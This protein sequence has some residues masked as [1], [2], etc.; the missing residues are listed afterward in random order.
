[1]AGGRGRA[2]AVRLGLGV[3]PAWAAASLGAVAAAGAW[4]EALLVAAPEELLFRGAV[5]GELRARTGR[6]VVA[7]VVA[8]LA[9][10][11]AHLVLSPSPASALTFLPGCLFGWLRLRSGSA[12]PAV[13]AHAVAN[14]AWRQW[15]AQRVGSMLPGVY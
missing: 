1:L 12:W 6:P 14:V 8:A 3:S 15:L 11:A 7:L 13:A 5:Q 2:L 9:F 10:A 4:R